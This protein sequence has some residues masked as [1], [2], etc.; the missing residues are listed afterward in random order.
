[1]K[2][3]RDTLESHLDQWVEYEFARERIKRL[4]L[5][6]QPTGADNKDV[7]DAGDTR[8]K[9]ESDPAVKVKNK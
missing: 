9:V 5:K 7:E 6:L 2:H 1:M 8:G 3:Y 4:K